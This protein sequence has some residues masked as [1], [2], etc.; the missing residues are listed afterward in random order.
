MKDCIYAKLNYLKLSETIL[1]CTKKL[2]SDLFKNV[3]FKICLE[4][5][6]LIYVQKGFV[7][8]WPTNVLVVGLEEKEKREMIRRRRRGWQE[9]E[10]GED[11]LLNQG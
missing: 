8:K 11:L 1:L 3:I 6:F 5:I 10:E 9:V 2:S 4:I 7:I